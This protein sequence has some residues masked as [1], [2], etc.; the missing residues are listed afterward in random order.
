MISSCVRLLRL[1]QVTLVLSSRAAREPPPPRSKPSRRPAS[2]SRNRPPSS[3]R[4][5]SR[6]CGLPARPNGPPYTPCTQRSSA[7]HTA[8]LSRARN[9]LFEPP[10]VPPLSSV[11]QTHHMPTK[12]PEVQQTRL[13]YASVSFFLVRVA[14]WVAQHHT[15][16]S[17][18]S[19]G[20]DSGRRDNGYKAI[21]LFPTSQHHHSSPPAIS[22]F[23]SCFFV[24]VGPICMDIKLS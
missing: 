19:C 7:R 15:S 3:V 24:H 8:L 12:H 4:R 1:A 11:E 13:V 5:C 14:Q 10:V 16:R 23:G 2:P 17:G 9:A 20:E 6:P 18:L 22:S 21:L